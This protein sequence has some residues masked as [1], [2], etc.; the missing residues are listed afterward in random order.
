MT[1]YKPLVL[2]S[3]VVTQLPPGDTVAGASGTGGATGAGGD[4]VFILN[5]KWVTTSYTLPT[6]WN[7]VSAGP[8]IVSGA[9]NVYLSGT[10][11][12]VIV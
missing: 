2:V 8:V 4:Q 10:S 5:N 6:N 1:V 7:A 3:G 12:W 11:N 9:A